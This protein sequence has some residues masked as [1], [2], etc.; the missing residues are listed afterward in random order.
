MPIVALTTGFLYWKVIKRRCCKG[1]Q[2]MSGGGC[3]TF[4]NLVVFL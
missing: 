3:L 4:I 1:L 2:D